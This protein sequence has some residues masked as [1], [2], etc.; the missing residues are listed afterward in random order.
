MSQFI[1][2]AAFVLVGLLF[3]ALILCCGFFICRIG[4]LAFLFGN[5]ANVFGE[6]TSDDN[7]DS[8]SKEALESLPVVEFKDSNISTEDANCGICL[9]S[10]ESNDLIKL[11]PCGHHFHSDCIDQW[12]S[13]NKTCPY[14]KQP[15][16]KL[17]T[18]EK[19]TG[20]KTEEV[21]SVNV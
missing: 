2:I 15:A 3:V 5:D 11:L 4:F 13:V 1:I 18:P 17:A 19:I 7:S 14:C 8:I 10:Y 16:D 21:E 20:P 6:H 9:C 12:L